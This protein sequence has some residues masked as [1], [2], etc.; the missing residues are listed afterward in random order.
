MFRMQRAASLAQRKEW[1]PGAGGD[2]EMQEEG[3]QI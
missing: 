1:G 2:K 3:P